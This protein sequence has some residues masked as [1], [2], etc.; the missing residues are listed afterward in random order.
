[1]YRRTTG[2]TVHI[3]GGV[4]SAQKQGDIVSEI[5]KH[6]ESE[7]KVVEYELTD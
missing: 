3:V 7:G 6:Q 2:I 4:T 5:G 1:L